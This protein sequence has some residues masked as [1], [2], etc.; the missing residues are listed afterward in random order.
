MDLCDPTS[1]AGCF[2]ARLAVARRATVPPSTRGTGAPPL[3]GPS[4]GYRRGRF[5]RWG[6][7]LLP[8]SAHSVIMSGIPVSGWCGCMCSG[9][10]LGVPGISSLRAWLTAPVSVRLGVLVLL[11][12]APLLAE[13]PRGGAA[14][15]ACH[16]RSVPSSRPSSQRG[17]GGSYG[18]SHEMDPGE[19]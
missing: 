18:S 9:L 13:S 4:A 8:P 17:M 12:L 19:A 3:L 7:N 5:R 14:V 1:R 6:K 11:I 10:G 15:R 16:K 2:T